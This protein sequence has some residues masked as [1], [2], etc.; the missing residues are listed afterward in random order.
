VIDADTWHAYLATRTVRRPQRRT[1][2]SPYLLSGLVKCMFPLEQGPCGAGMTGGRFNKGTLPMFRC[3][4]MTQTHA[5]R[6]GYVGM[7]A[8]EEEVIRWLQVE[9]QGVDVRKAARTDRPT[10]RPQIDVDVLARELVGL[11]RQLVELTRQLA[12][13]V[14]PEAAYVT[15]RDEIDAAMEALSQRHAQAVLDAREPVERARLAASLL[16][17]WPALLVEERREIL[18]RLILRVDVVPGRRPAGIE[19]IPR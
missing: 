8:V 12:R 10:R 6:R 7:R 3:N 4:A 11:Q 16:G 19:I 9:A 2:R 15:A 5:H 13:R 14:I 1:Q 18:G 17:D